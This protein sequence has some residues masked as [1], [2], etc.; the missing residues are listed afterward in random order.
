L[1][2]KIFNTGKT[3]PEADLEMIFD[4]FYQF[5][6]QNILKPTGSGLRLAIQKR[7]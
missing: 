3:I 6:N 5:K 7:S 1:I 4:T 2:I